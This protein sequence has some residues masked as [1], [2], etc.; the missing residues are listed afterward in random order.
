MIVVLCAISHRLDSSRS[1]LSSSPLCEI[2]S[3]QTWTCKS[4]TLVTIWSAYCSDIPFPRRWNVSFPSKIL[5]F[6]MVFG[7]SAIDLT[8]DKLKWNLAMSF[9]SKRKQT[10]PNTFAEKCKFYFH[11]TYIRHWEKWTRKK[12]ENPF[13]SRK[14]VIV[15]KL[16]KYINFIVNYVDETSTFMLAEKK[17][18]LFKNNSI[19]WLPRGWTT[20]TISPCQN[21]S[22][23]LEQS[24]IKWL[25]QQYTSNCQLFQLNRNL[26]RTFL[27]KSIFNWIPC[28]RF[29]M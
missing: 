29:R 6:W 18:I 22:I 26:F 25:N 1:S 13:C 23:R 17:T 3:F 10:S 5:I 20:S 24:P 2:I 9:A 27:F 4:I 16:P 11:R 21:I 28:L 8:F 15:S 7:L 14:K 19:H 12:S